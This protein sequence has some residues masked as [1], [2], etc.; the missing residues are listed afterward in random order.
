MK[1]LYQITWNKAVRDLISTGYY[2][3]KFFPR[4]SVRFVSINDRFDTLDGITNISFERGS[5]VRIPITN[6]FCRL[7]IPDIA[8]EK[9]IQD[10]PSLIREIIQVM[11]TTGSSHKVY[12]SSFL[13]D[14]LMKHDERL[15]MG[16]AIFL[17][18]KLNLSIRFLCWRLVKSDIVYS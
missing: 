13:L 6:Y 10:V 9:P 17:E 3:E 7:Y 15:L 8:I 18:D 5:T 1:C 16:S 2:I 14:F 11:E 4:N 12:L